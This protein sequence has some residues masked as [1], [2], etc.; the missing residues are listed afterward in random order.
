MKR[1]IIALLQARTDSSRLPKKVLK[2]ILNKP[3]IIHQLQRTSKSKLIDKLIL[4][5][6]NEKN[7]DELSRVVSQY[8]F[9]IYRGDKNNVLK[10]FYDSLESLKLK[11]D[12]IIVRLTGDCPLHDADIIDES[13]NAFLGQNCDYL[14]N[15]VEPV[16]P[17][18]LDV[19]VFNFKSLRK[20]YQEADKISQLEHVT[21]YIIDCG[22]FKICNL[23]KESIYSNWRLTVDEASDF[24][25]IEKIYHHFNTTYFSFLDIVKFLEKNQNLLIINSSIKRNEGY[26]KSLK[27]DNDK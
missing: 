6:S 27:E 11:Q 23:N 12:D 15:S 21:P 20:A 18:G 1:K 14:S 7:D 26:I 9:S 17:D 19:E 24:K 3:M 2:L 25:L 5:T 10:R 16:Y 22:E 13:I 4:V 8:N